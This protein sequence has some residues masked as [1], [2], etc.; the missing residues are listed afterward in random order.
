MRGEIYN[1]GTA[2]KKSSVFIKNIIEILPKVRP[3]VY[4][5]ALA[6]HITMTFFPL[7]ICLYTLLGNSYDSLMRILKIA[8][9]VLAKDTLDLIYGFAEYIAANNSPAMMAAAIAILVTSASAAIRVIHWAIGKMQGGDRFK[10]V[11]EI[12]ISF[13]FSLIFLTAI[14]FAVI[15][16]FTGK[17]FIDLVNK[18]V[19]YFDIRRSWNFLRYVLLAAIFFV[20]LTLLFRS[21]RR[22][23]DTYSTL[24]GS[25]IAAVAVVLASFFFSAIIKKSTK[26]SLVYGSL[27]SIVLLMLWLFWC[28]FMIIFGAAINVVIRDTREELLKAAIAEERKKKLR[29]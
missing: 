2:M 15:V 1:A 29:T 19:P 5:A 24:P 4:A 26:Y 10:D 11:W 18:Y 25:S 23:T 21:A 16:M 22:K 20:L 7:L 3:G 6:F 27:A 14:Y 28:C 12:A 8:E 13:P 17:N 9:G